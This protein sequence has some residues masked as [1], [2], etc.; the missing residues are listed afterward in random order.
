MAASVKIAPLEHKMDKD[1]FCPIA[2]RITVNRKVRY[3][4]IGQ[5]IQ[6][7]HWTTKEGGMVKSSHPN[8]KMMNT[9]L[10]NKRAE[11][12]NQLMKAEI[13]SPDYTSSH[14]K[15][16]IRGDKPTGDFFEL[17]YRHL[18]ELDKVNKISRLWS[19]RPRVKHFHEFVKAT[20]SSTLPFHEINESLLKKFRVYLVGK[21]NAKERTVMNYF[22]VIRTILNRAIQEGLSDKRH[23]PFGKGK[24]RIKM[25]ESI[26]IGLTREEVK[27]IEELELTSGSAIWHARNV[28]LT[29]FYFAGVRLG[30]VLKLKWSDIKDQRLY[31]TMGKNGK[32]V[33]VRIPD[34]AYDIM[35][36]YQSGRDD[37]G[38]IF[39]ELKSVDVNNIARVYR[40]TSTASKKFAR[41]MNEIAATCGI[42]KKITTHIARHTFGNISGDKISP[43]MLQKLYR[44][45]DIRTTMGYQANFI[46]READEALDSVINF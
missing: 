21:R 22:V 6:L 2:V 27:L 36:Q 41:Y 5:K 43:Q 10:A 24:I 4:Y 32:V 1:G 19:E 30:D 42:K 15:K 44:H 25:P 3:I 9:L 26:K 46:F 31:Y 37:T 20:G 8:F 29:S 13:E 38:Y 17:A 35:Q 40:K 28:W 33:S 12:A 23:Y 18:D 11:V 7:Q 14:I 16:S 39:P 34:K 45:S